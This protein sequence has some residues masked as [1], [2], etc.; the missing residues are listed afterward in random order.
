MIQEKSRKFFLQLQPCAETMS[1]SK[2]ATSHEY[3]QCKKAV[4]TLSLRRCDEHRWSGACTIQLLF[5]NVSTGYNYNVKKNV[6][7]S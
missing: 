1:T 5:I 6:N 7:L 4:V 2:N 3:T